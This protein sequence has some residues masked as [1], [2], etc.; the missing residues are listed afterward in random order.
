MGAEFTNEGVNLYLH[1]G[2]LFI[3]AGMG[4]GLLWLI[5]MLY[6]AF[7]DHT[8]P[9][10]PTSDR[11]W[12]KAVC[13]NYLLFVQLPFTVFWWHVLKARAY[14]DTFA[15]VMMVLLVFCCVAL[16]VRPYWASD[17]KEGREVD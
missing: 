13:W 8:K 16:V 1:P 5:A 15:W 9:P 2:T 4:T 17:V 7:A 6:V 11:D 12:A 14:A 10:K 3:V